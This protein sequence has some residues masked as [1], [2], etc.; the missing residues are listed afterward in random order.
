MMELTLKRIA[1]LKDYTIGKLYIN[2]VYFCD[3]LEDTVRDLNKNGAFDNGEIKIPDRTAIPY[4]TYKITLDVRSPKYSNF[5][6]YPWA[7][8]YN[9][10]IPRLL[11]V[12]NFEGIL[13]HPGN[14]PEH[15]SGCLLPGQNKVKGQ[16]INSTE[17]FNQLM[18]K[19]LLPAKYRGEQITIEIK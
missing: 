4:G 18:S 8:Q 5:V 6:K 11:G 12:N 7:K 2:N 10:F 13:I 19:Y 15:T 17:T 16:V 1:L 9:G 3:V 14:K